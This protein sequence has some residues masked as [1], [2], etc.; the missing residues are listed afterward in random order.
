MM[1]V[2]KSFLFASHNRKLKS[3]RENLLSLK[4][5]LTHFQLIYLKVGVYKNIY[6]TA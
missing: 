4:R 3:L 6:V 5:K 1:I 2:V